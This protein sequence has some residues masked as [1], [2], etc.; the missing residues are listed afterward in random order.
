M[1]RENPWFPWNEILQNNRFSSIFV[2]RPT[3]VPRLKDI[4][5]KTPARIQANYMFF[6]AIE[7]NLKQ[8]SLNYFNLMKSSTSNYWCPL[9]AKDHFLVP[10]FHEYV[11]KY[12]RYLQRDEILK[13]GITENIKNEYLKQMKEVKLS[14]IAF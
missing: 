14:T 12:Y 6:K 2:T 8:I 9:I 13:S 1:R 10:V 5:E 3:L 7:S 11:K 4:L